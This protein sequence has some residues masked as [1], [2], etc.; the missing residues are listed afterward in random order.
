[1]EARV[2]E[3]VAAIEGAGDLPRRSASWRILRTL[4]IAAVAT[5]LLA[6][7]AVTNVLQIIFAPLVLVSRPL[8]YEVNS[9]ATFFAWS[10]CQYFVEGQDNVTMTFSGTAAVPV[11][12]S[13]VVICN[14]VYFGD[15]FLIHHIARRKRMMAYGRYFAKDS[16]KY[17]P[18]FG[19]GMYLCNMPFLKRNWQSDGRSLAG[20]LALYTRYSLPVW[21]VSHVEGSRITA[22]KLAEC[23]RFGEKNGLPTMRNVLLPRC[24]GFIATINEFRGGHVKFVYDVTLAYYHRR[25]GWG[26]TPSI[27]QVFTG[28]LGEYHMHAHIDRIPIADIPTEEAAITRWM[29][30]LYAK[31]D[32]FLSSLKEAFVARHKRHG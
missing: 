14:H 3:A 4:R 11:R 12:E 29:Y 9:F 1:M 28:D 6:V 7:G 16:L 22:K 2:A 15:F 20:S 23:N 32:A 18:I 13:A 5:L 26:A 27:L 8:S 31:K 24:K 25:R 30:D 17:M 21:L 10:F 19:W